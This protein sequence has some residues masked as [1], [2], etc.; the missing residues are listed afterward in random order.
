MDQP[1]VFSVVLALILALLLALILA[2]V[3]AAYMLRRQTSSDTDRNS[4]SAP[5]GLDTLV[6]WPPE[7]MRVLNPAERTAH[8]LLARALPNHMIFAQLPLSRFVK[9]ESRYPYA[10]WLR[11][12][13]SHCVDLVVADPLSR[14]I[15]VIEVDALNAPR[16]SSARH[17][18]VTRVLKHLEI[19][20]YEWREGELPSL[21][22]LRDL[23]QVAEDEMEKTV[24]LFE[25]KALP[26]T[27]I[28]PATV[29]FYI[30]NEALLEAGREGDT[31]EAGLCE[32]ANPTTGSVPAAALATFE[33][34]SLDLPPISLDLAPATPTASE[35]FHAEHRAVPN[36]VCETVLVE[37]MLHNE[38]EPALTSSSVGSSGGVEGA[39]NEPASTTWHGESV[40]QV[41]GSAHS[42]QRGS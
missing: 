39:A 1:I 4:P 24:C 2:V 6:A 41:N 31:E 12:V 8:D 26:P 20:L 34:I 35:G 30:A 15:A 17:Q 38:P 23:F 37:H 9:V 14:V 28:D 36:P 18:D 32:M 5:N 21:D 25:A 33:G 3:T 7:S 11:R 29:S 10:Q 16:K 42:S 13:G 27:P 19:P 40:P 22:Q